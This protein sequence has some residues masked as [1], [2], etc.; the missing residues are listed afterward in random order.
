MGPKDIATKEDPDSDLAEILNYLHRSGPD[1]QRLMEELTLY[2]IFHP[3]SFAAV[4]DKVL[5]AMGLFYKIQEPQSLYSFLIRQMGEAHRL[6]SGVVLTPVQASVRRALEDNQFV[7]ISAP[8]SAGKSYSIRDFIAN[9]TGDAVVVVPSRALIAEYLA[10]MRRIFAEDKSVMVM[11]FVDRVFTERQLRR[12]FVLT[13]ERARDLFDMRSELAVSTFFFDEAQIS[14]E[15]QRGVV[16]DVLVR[17]IGRA[18]PNAKLVFAHPFVDNPEA[19]ISKHDLSAEKSFSRSYPF[20]AVGKA[21]VFGHGNG[22]DY[23]FSPYEEGGH[24]LKNCQAFGS[25]FAEFAFG[26][27]HSVL[28]YVTKNSIYN[29]SFLDDFR[30]LINAFEEIVD[31]QAL[32]IISAIERLLGA[33]Q[34]SHRSKMVALLR[35]GVVIHHGSVPLEVR[36]LVEEYV[37]QGH[38]RICFATSTLVQG[39]N[40]P[41]DV[42]WLDTSRIQGEN[43]GAKALAFKNLIGRAGRLTNQPRFDFGYV[44]TRSPQVVAERLDH[45]FVLSPTSVIDEQDLPDDPD[46]A[47]ILDS[48]RSDTF[49]EQ[50]HLPRSK[51]DRLAQDHVRKAAARILDLIY[52]QG[53]RLSQTLRGTANRRTRVQLEESFRAIF[54]ASIDRQLKP[55]EE[56]VFRTAISLLLRTFQGRPFS[57]IVGQRFNWIGRR[58][59]KRIGN[60]EFAQRANKLPDAS[61][62]RPFPLFPLGTL[63]RDISYD[64]VVFDTYDYLDQVIS[65]GLNDV[66]MAAF[67]IFYAHTSDVRALKM[68]ELLRFGTNDDVQVLL[69]RYGFLPEDIPEIIPYLSSISERRIVFKSTVET[70]SARLRELT[71]WYL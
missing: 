28:V 21:F 52:A 58:D 47:E 46:V 67:K 60:A 5:A 27:G 11:P 44:Y 48:L 20:A 63:A 50:L 66:F 69:M 61:L 10:V 49:D 7:S 3:A 39:V 31:E 12:I 33:N 24:L 55:G 9:G 19:Q 40:M 8:T 37:R 56:A 1:T 32:E 36:F 71:A 43:E 51:A 23:Y 42:V 22:S 16:F 18:F 29:E 2:R 38:A 54:E 70:A 15:A 35:R 6:E 59:R 34:S 53:E 57:E 14:E 25:S 64:T 62:E 13:P 65:F 41:F 45:R 68:I 30:D 4:E 17:R 26:Q